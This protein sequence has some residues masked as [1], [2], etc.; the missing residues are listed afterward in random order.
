MEGRAAAA[1]PS[2][3][4]VVARVDLAER[5]RLLR[6]TP[7]DAEIARRVLA[8]LEPHAERICAGQI[9]GWFDLFPSSAPVDR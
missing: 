7:T 5:H 1:A 6:F 4:D 9:D 3:D 2:I 8:A